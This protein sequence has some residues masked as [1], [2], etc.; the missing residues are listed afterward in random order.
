MGSIIE[1]DCGCVESDCPDECAACKCVEKLSGP[2]KL[3]A[4]YICGETVITSGEIQTKINDSILTIFVVL[5]W[6]RIL[7]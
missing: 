6:S 4:T 1:A 5:A 2:E 7:V 3:C